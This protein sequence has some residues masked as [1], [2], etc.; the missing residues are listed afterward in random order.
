MPPRALSIR[1]LV[2]ALIR[3]RLRTQLSENGVT[4]ICN[5]A[6]DVKNFFP[7]HFTYVNLVML[8]N[9]RAAQARRFC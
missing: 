8:R 7:Q 1:I 3:R 5:A 2:F 4:H 9:A 6:D